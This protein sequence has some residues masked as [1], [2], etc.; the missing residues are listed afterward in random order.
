MFVA[1]AATV[2]VCSVDQPKFA[3]SSVLCEL[4]FLLFSY[5]VSSGMPE[6]PNE[7]H[8]NNNNLIISIALKFDERI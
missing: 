3:H 2:V 5:M 7:I 8:T 6:R 4:F 1:V